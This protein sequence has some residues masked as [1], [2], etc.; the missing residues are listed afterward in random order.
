MTSN[1]VDEN[2]SKIDFESKSGKGSKFWF[3]IPLKIADA[4]D[5]VPIDELESEDDLPAVGELRVL[6]AARI[7]DDELG[8][9]TLGA[10]NHAVDG[11]PAVSLGVVAKERD[12]LCERVVGLGKPA[13]DHSIDRRRIA[14]AI[15]HP[16]DPVG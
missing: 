14:H 15:G 5:A 16:A 4:A 11:R 3:D 7:T 1:F 2:A 9:S 10:P 8:A 6:A 12:A 13:V